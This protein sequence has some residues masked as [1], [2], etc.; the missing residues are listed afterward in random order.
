MLLSD[1]FIH[2]EIAK[3]INSISRGWTF[4]CSMLISSYWR[5]IKVW[6]SIRK[7]PCTALQHRA[8]SCRQRRWQHLNA[9]W[10]HW[11]FFTPRSPRHLVGSY[12]ETRCSWFDSH[13]R[14]FASGYYVPMLSSTGPESARHLMFSGLPHKTVSF[15]VLR[16]IKL[17]GKGN[18]GG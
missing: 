18:I 14:H 4:E 8:A 10:R 16:N 2:D 5:R 12:E 13:S 15:I 17:H 9:V 11:S 6:I 1:Y 3:V 7:C